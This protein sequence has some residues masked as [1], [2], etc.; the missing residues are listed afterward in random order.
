MAKE[1]FNIEITSTGEVKVTFKDVAGVHVTEY[2]EILTKM[3]GPLQE[4]KVHV[5]T[6]KYN[7]EPKVGIVTPDTN[8]I[9]KKS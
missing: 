3:I 8:S 7:P 5:K 1:E 6:G 4:D 2:V 9:R